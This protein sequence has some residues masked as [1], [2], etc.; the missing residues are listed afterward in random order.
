M[1]R[2]SNLSTTA[3]DQDLTDIRPLLEEVFSFMAEWLETRLETKV[4]KQWE[5]HVVRIL[6][7][8]KEKKHIQS[9][10]WSTVHDLDEQSKIRVFER[11]YRFLEQKCSFPPSSEYLIGKVREVRNNHIAHRP[12]RGVKPNSALR[13]LDIIDEFLELLEAPRALLKRVE[14]HQR[15]LRELIEAKQVSVRGGAFAQATKPVGAPIAEPGFEDVFEG[16]R[17]TPSQG[18]AVRKLDQFLR[19]P[20]S[21]CFVLKGYAGTGKTFLIGGLYRYLTKLKTMTMLMAPTGR[22][23]HV[24]S[25]RHQVPASTIHRGIYTLDKLEEFPEVEEDGTIAY[26]M[27]FSLRNNDVQHDT[28]FIVDEASMISDVYQEA[29]FVRFGSGRL[30]RDLLEFI[31][32]DANDYSK[33]LILI[34]DD[35]QLPP[36]GMNTSPALDV[37][38]LKTNGRID[39]QQHLLTD[40]VR[41]EESSLILKNATA[42]RELLRK[43]DYSA[44]SFAY[45]DDSV[46]NLQ[47]D[48]VLDHFG[49]ISED[50]DIESVIITYANNTAKNYNDAVR[51]YIFKRGKDISP[52]DR[53]IVIRNNYGHEIELFNGQMGIVVDVGGEEEHRIVRFYSGLDDDGKRRIVEV[54]LRYQ[55]VTIEFKDLS[56]ETHQIS[57]VILANILHSINRDLSTD[58]SKALYIDFKNRH[59]DLK[60][61][62]PRFR[63]VLLA[64][65]YFNA[66][67]VKYG[68]AIT[69][70]KSQG[71]EWDNV[72]IDF[73]S[74][75]KLNA[76]AL[77]W[78]YTALTR[79]RKR[80]ILT[81]PIFQDRLVPRKGIE[82]TEEGGESEV[83]STDDVEVP[84]EIAERG[85][86]PAGIYRLVVRCLSEDIE[87]TSTHSINYAEKY[88]FT[89]DDNN[90]CRIVIYYDKKS[91]IKTI[92]V[93]QKSNDEFGA[94]IKKALKGLAGKKTASGECKQKPEDIIGNIAEY[95]RI[96]IAEINKRLQDEPISIIS[97]R[98]I[99][100]YSMEIHFKDTKETGAAIYYFDKS[101]RLTTLSIKGSRSLYE[102]WKAIHQV[103]YE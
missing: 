6:N 25:E 56:G 63:E 65:P 81:N 31:N 52:G 89:D 103:A 53:L 87:I 100:Q 51:K 93:E 73:K 68:Y 26:K 66:L 20:D 57:C 88:R 13:A 42:L 76:T 91:V 101:K 4:R 49:A 90:T 102:K 39:V 67:L 34:G 12:G 45:D 19:D 5:K 82:W 61:H 92:H 28:I 22:A 85:V 58:E 38:Y 14:N 96:I 70:H 9:G 55:H 29:E 18:E 17:L 86:I 62:D 59:P 3:R 33:K 44:F 74:Q 94:R 79:A 75:N 27:Y 48:E 78:S 32:F 47:P 77:R 36:V 43:R 2:S 99:S 95:K 71:G 46:I 97:I 24:I 40:V 15:Q 72:Y 16:F 35:A 50:M 69:G 84:E 83:P 54:Q 98:D 64:D 30:L 41:Q 23:A 7:S 8:G 80:V 11:N 21:K 10:N 37:D 60:P 1:H